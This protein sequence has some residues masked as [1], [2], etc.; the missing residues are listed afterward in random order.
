MRISEDFL[1]ARRWL[2]CGLLF[3]TMGVGCGSRP[4]SVSG[5]VTFDGRPLPSGTVLFHGPDGRVA[6][7]LITAEGKYVIEDAPIGKVRISVE[8]HGAAPAGLPSSGRNA[9][10]TPPELAPRP[11]D[12]RDSKAVSIPTRY[13]DPE[14]SGLGYEVRPGGQTHNIELRP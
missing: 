8:S 11:E 1:A 6:H 13:L 5:K 3:M 2:A 7:A 9:P 4:A 10:A 12:P 14:K